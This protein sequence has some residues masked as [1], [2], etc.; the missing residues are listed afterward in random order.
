M[1]ELRL[2]I[3]SKSIFDRTKSWSRKSHKS[4]DLDHCQGQASNINCS[5][6]IVLTYSVGIPI[7]NMYI[8]RL[9]K[10][11]YSPAKRR[12]RIDYFGTSRQ[13]SNK[14]AVSHIRR[15]IVWS[16]SIYCSSQAYSHS[17]AEWFCLCSIIHMIKC[18]GAK[19]SAPNLF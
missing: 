11:L 7:G 19:E 14:F 5:S 15:R 12:K 4:F 16:V 3:G 18:A 10:T 1:Y 17:R 6:R 8:W 9:G 13:G 2:N